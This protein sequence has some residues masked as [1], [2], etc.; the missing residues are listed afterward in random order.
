MTVLLTN[1]TL[2]TL[3]PP[4]FLSGHVG[5][6]GEHI[7]TVSGARPNGTWDETVDCTGRLII[8][9]NVCAHTHL[10]SALA[11]GMPGPRVQP[12]NFLEILQHI[13]WRL[14]RALDEPGN[15]SSALIGAIDAV[16]AGTTTLVDH[17]ASPN[18]IGG[19]LDVLADSLGAVGV[20]GVLCYEVTDRDGRERRDQGL[21]ENDRFL[22]SNRRPLIR[23]NVGA[24]AS[25]TLEDDSLSALAEL[26]RHHDTGVHVHV[27]EDAWD[28][29][30]A[31][32][33]CGRR[34]ADRLAT[35]GILNDN[36]VAAHGVHLDGD[37]LALVQAHGSWLVHNCRSNLNNSV[38]Y[39]PVARFGQKVALGTDGIDGDMFAESRTAFFRAREASLSTP[40]EEPARMLAGGAALASSYFGAPL[41]RI[42]PGALAD[43]VVL[44][45]DPP[46]E[47]TAGNFAWHWMFGLTSA[48]VESVMVG[49][50][51]VM[52]S[53]ELVGVDEEKV[54]A[55]ARREASRLWKR[56]EEL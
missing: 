29:T 40:A 53:G 28:E 55:E 37:E 41:G 46:T 5:V 9:G 11:R 20:R 56:M 23:G 4:T 34:T 44:N 6:Q 49:G 16:R 38:G 3:Y 24:H 35:A 19:S 12:T 15:R 27:A 31:L 30:D 14:D 36:S 45:Y 47:L 50:K 32:R 52:K 25:F 1:A 48:G 39:A 18:A 42:Q 13:W 8:P 26:A 2:A 51:W 21:E 54:R 33:R 22:S 7:Q 43:L 17:H 10:Y